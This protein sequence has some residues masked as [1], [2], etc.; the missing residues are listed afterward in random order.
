M[1]DWDGNGTQTP[2][3]YNPNNS[4]FYLKNSFPTSS[5]P[6]GYSPDDAYSVNSNYPHGNIGDTIPVAG[7]W[8]ASQTADSGG[9]YD[10]ATSTF[11]LFNVLNGTLITVQYGPAGAG[12]YPVVGDWTNKGYD[13]IGLYD[14]I[15]SAFFLRNSNTT[16]PA[17]LAFDYGPAGAG[18]LPVV[19]DWNGDGVV[20]IGL[21]DVAGITF[22]L[23]NQNA[24]HP[25]DLTFSYGPGPGPN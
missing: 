7:H 14:P 16:G 20:T 18:W 15:D 11:Y 22:Y 10:P 12:W 19:G 6:N 9:V 21:Y 1:G 5:T 2:G 13:S 4:E 24:N 17:D 25:A 8:S 23:S 3:M